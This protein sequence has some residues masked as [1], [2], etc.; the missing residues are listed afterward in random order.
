ETICKDGFTTNSTSNKTYMRTY[1]NPLPTE[2]KISLLNISKNKEPMTEFSFFSS[3]EINEIQIEDFFIVSN[4][5]EREGNFRIG[6][7]P[8]EFSLIINYDARLESSE[9]EFFQP[10]AFNNSLIPRVVNFDSI[11]QYIASIFY[12]IGIKLR[13]IPYKILYAPTRDLYFQLNAS[14]P[15]GDID[16]YILEGT[17]KYISVNN[18]EQ[19]TFYKDKFGISANI[20][21]SSL[22]NSTL[23]LGTEKKIDLVFENNSL[24]GKLCI[25]SISENKTK[26]D[27]ENNIE[28]T[29]EIDLELLSF[30]P[31][32]E[33]IN[34]TMNLSH[35]SY[36]SSCKLSNLT[37]LSLGKNYFE[38]TLYE[39]PESFK[40]IQM[41][42]E[43]SIKCNSE[44]GLADI[45]FYSSYHSNCTFKK[46]P[47]QHILIYKTSKNLSKPYN[48]ANEEYASIR[49]Y[50]L[51]NFSIITSKE[52]EKNELKLHLDSFSNKELRMVIQN[53]TLNLAEHLFASIYLSTFPNS[54]DFT[55]TA[56]E[57]TDNFALSNSFYSRKINTTVS[58]LADIAT[59]LSSISSIGSILLSNLMNISAYMCDNLGLGNSISFSYS[60]DNSTT[61]HVYGIIDKGTLDL[62]AKWQH[63]IFLAALKS[64]FQLR[65]F[66]ENLP[67]KGEIEFKN[68]NEEFAF[69]L[70]LGSYAPCYEYIAATIKGLKSG[71][72]HIHIGL[73]KNAKFD[74]LILNLSVKLSDTEN[75]LSASGF[76]KLSSSPPGM[77]TNMSGDISRQSKIS[78]NSRTYIK[79]TFSNIPSALD[80]SFLIVSGKKIDILYSSSST[81]N[82][83]YLS[84]LQERIRIN[85]NTLHTKNNYANITLRD[86][87]PSLTFHMNM[88]GNIG[89][90]DLLSPMASFPDIF[91]STNAN[92]LDIYADIDGKISGLNGKYRICAENI[93]DI[94]CKLSDR[95][96]I[97]SNGS[98]FI[99]LLIENAISNIAFGLGDVEKITFYAE[100]LKSANI[101]IATSLLFY[102][103][104][105]ID[106][107]DANCFFVSIKAN[108]LGKIPLYAV[109]LTTNPI[110]STLNYAQFT[111]G[112]GM[113]LIAFV[114]SAI[115]TMPIL[116]P[117]TIFSWLGYH[118]YIKFKKSKEQNAKEDR[119]DEKDSCKKIP[120]V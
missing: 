3:E 117:I 48:K 81:I 54:I 69:L 97:K 96:I 26:Q 53:D 59:I 24:S 20:H 35:I 108:I 12:N 52:N 37:F 64:N 7:I 86:L 58:G 46:L 75:G 101:L 10:P 93:T 1:L 32:P 6:K 92:T 110:S 87:P 38:I 5:I 115:I 85:D 77:F 22:S 103:T 27:S 16:I 21:L 84:I 67:A 60:L 88:R 89:N 100:N 61:M 43:T 51:S 68:E 113:L 112:N 114:P 109:I 79:F 4:K 63:G 13:E 14:K 45:S 8:K 102:P 30:A 19:I 17:R 118:R 18:S 44:I 36:N 94:S 83:L 50:N 62:D 104:V 70:N 55:F 56:K 29:N 49:L 99:S 107:L 66:L 116:I 9:I 119:N 73:A 76:A 78:M 80:T 40:I 2:L 95:Y 120:K 15:I 65:L 47:G 25:L 106:G 111:N 33:H 57:D 105:N 42:G 90:I 34:L 98:D 11:M 71:D 28:N 91:L 23:R 31:V 82:L 41:Q 72:A 74:Y 39:V